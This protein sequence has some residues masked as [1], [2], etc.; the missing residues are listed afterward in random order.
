MKYP[1]VRQPDT[2]GVR[3]VRAIIIGIFFA[4]IV[5]PG[6][7]MALGFGSLTKILENRKLA[8]W[9]KQEFTQDVSGY[10]TALQSWF[11]DHF[12]LR[13]ELVKLRG[14]IDYSLFDYS[15]RVHIGRDGWLFYRSV[16][17]VQKP[18]VD[19]YL[20]TDGGKV[21]AGIEVLMRSLRQRGVTLVLMTPPMKDD[22]YGE[23]LP[24]SA[25]RVPA[26]TRAESLVERLKR[27]DGLV[28][29]DALSILRETAKKRQVF[30]RTDFHWN[31]AAAYEVAKSLVDQ[32]SRREGR[33]QSAWP[34][35]LTITTRDIVGG[36][37][38]FIPM[39]WTIH[40]QG[41]F[42]DDKRTVPNPT[43]VNGPAPFLYHMDQPP[44]AR[45]LP[46][47]AV[48]GD[49]FFDGIERAGIYHP[50][51]KYYRTSGPTISQFVDGLPQDARYA[52][53]EF[54]EI[55]YGR[56]IEFASMAPK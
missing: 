47:I 14:Q 4:I 2:S 35:E 26:P 29:V 41:M 24:L 33:P 31:D 43:Y 38:I 36:E 19:R 39:F 44:N 23:F 37:S 54:I 27:V 48:L 34:H 9:P 12:G 51:Q 15:A 1:K 30:H 50:F 56:L 40:E 20:A 17:D 3:R 16:M 25:R 8:D 52:V 18:G 49:S 22:L 7:S 45:L 13:A 53:V 21:V 10:L 32:I 5:L 11:D 55:S 42:V 6:L 46:P 28:F